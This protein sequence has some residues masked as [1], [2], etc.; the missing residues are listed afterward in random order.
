MKWFL[1]IYYQLNMIIYLKGDKYPNKGRIAEQV[2]ILKALFGIPLKDKFLQKHLNRIN[3][4]VNDKKRF[5]RDLNRMRT[6]K[7]IY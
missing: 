5:K 4:V 6:A 1:K 2:E 7:W 3:I